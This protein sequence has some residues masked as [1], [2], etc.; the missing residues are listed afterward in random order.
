MTPPPGYPQYPYQGPLPP[1]PRP[2]RGGRVALGIGAAVLAHI[3]SI[4]LGL[5]V[6]AALSGG[7]QLSGA[8]LTILIGQVLVFVACIALGIVLL[9]RGDRGIG[10]GLLI[11]WAVGVL[12]LPVVGFGVCVA[13]LSGTGVGG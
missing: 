8:L 12:V 10:L 13:A 2:I 3:L 4:A 1:N 7:D 9:V 6:G 11:G 5:G